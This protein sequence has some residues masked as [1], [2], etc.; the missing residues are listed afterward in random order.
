MSS[1][2]SGRS[3][4]FGIPHVFMALQMLHRDRFVSRA[5]L[6]RRLGLGEG[7][8][9]TLI[10]HM[11]GGGLADAVRAGTYLTEDGKRLAGVM[12]DVIPEGAAVGG[13]AG[14]LGGR[15]GHAVLVKNSAHV[16]HTGIEQRDYAVL[17]GAPVALTLVYQNGRFSFPGEESDALA[18]DGGA[19]RDALEGMRPEEND[20]VIVTAAD[21]PRVAEVAA[22]NSALM[23]VAI[24][25]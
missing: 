21:D 17:Y 2:G 6:C 18:G 14:M 4:T 3:L 1:R 5:S 11:K 7:A 15:H 12:T 16:I 13:A 24:L 8:V 23:T 9:R 22:K 10:L 25:A 19:M 20:V